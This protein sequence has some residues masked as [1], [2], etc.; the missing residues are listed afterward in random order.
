MEVDS[1]NGLFASLSYKSHWKNVWYRAGRLGYNKIRDLIEKACKANCI[2]E[3]GEKGGVITHSLRGTALILL[4][5]AETL[6]SAIIMR[7]RHRQIEIL[8]NY[9]TLRGEQCRKQQHLGLG[10]SRKQEAHG[11]IGDEHIV[12]KRKSLLWITLMVSWGPWIIRKEA[13]LMS[14]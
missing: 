11:P 13:P 14:T 3:M 6:G 9:Q 12:A 10:S 7:T 4:I 8:E 5:E 2:K 1:N